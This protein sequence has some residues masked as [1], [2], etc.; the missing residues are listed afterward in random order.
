[1]AHVRTFSFF[2]Q[3][4]MALTYR[5]PTLA[6][7]LFGALSL[8]VSLLLVETMANIR[9]NDSFQACVEYSTIVHLYFGQ[10]SHILMQVFLYC[11]PQ[12]SNISSIIISNQVRGAPKYPISTE[13]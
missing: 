4:V 9:G 2:M 8:A 12:S 5:S 13:L 10:K 3:A 6:F 11:A 7:I 1:M